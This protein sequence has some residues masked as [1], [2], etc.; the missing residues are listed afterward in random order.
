MLKLAW[1]GLVVV[2]KEITFSVGWAELNTDGSWMEEGS[3]GAGMVLRDNMGQIIYTS[4]REIFLLQKRFEA[5]LSACMKGLSVAIQ[6]RSC[7]FMWRWIPDKLWAWS[8]ISQ[9]IDRSSLHRWRKS[10]IWGT[11]VELHLVLFIVVRIVLAI[12]W[13][14]LLELRVELSFG[15]TLACQK[16][17]SFVMQTVALIPLE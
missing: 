5:E 8:L 13:L 3:A 12:F 9:L 16:L 2:L 15:L 10:S 14:S 11:S 17:L 1:K 6:R 4:C 7:L